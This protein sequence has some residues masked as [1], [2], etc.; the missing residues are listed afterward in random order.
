M[1]E[2]I[3]GAIVMGYLVAG[4]HFLKF[5]KRS[6]DRLFGIFAAAFGILAVQ[7]LLLTVLVDERD[8]HI[9]LY[10]VRV[11]AFL[12]IIFAIVDKNRAGSR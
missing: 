11:L 5:W 9:L 3:S 2:L 1:R 4:L 10:L 12:L 6:D 8:A 7:R